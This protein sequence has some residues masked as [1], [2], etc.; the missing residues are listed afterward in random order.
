MTT[1]TLFAA[2]L[3]LAFCCCNFI[4]S[5]ADSGGEKRKPKDNMTYSFVCLDST[6]NGEEFNK[7]LLL[8]LK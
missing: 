3:G 8:F 1:K 2:T 4:D 7:V 6:L 5:N